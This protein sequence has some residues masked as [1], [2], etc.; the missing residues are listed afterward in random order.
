M[1]KQER[2]A[3]QDENVKRKRVLAEEKA[4]SK[5]EKRMK[6]ADDVSGSVDR[7]QY[8]EDADYEDADAED[9]DDDESDG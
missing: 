9:L 6:R 1:L 7:N 5:K 2:R 3:K 4:K 8:D